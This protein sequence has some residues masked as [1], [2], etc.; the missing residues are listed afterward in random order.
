MTHTATVNGSNGMR[1]S[2]AASVQFPQTPT[3][4]PYPSAPAQPMPYPMPAPAALVKPGVGQRITGP[5]RAHPSLTALILA[6]LA[7]LVIALP[8]AHGIVQSR[9]D[10]QWQPSSSVPSGTLPGGKPHMGAGQWATQTVNAAELNY[11]NSIIAHM[12][13]QQEVGQ[14]IMIEFEESQMT[15]GLAYE[16]SHYNVG[17]VILYAYNVLNPTQMQQFT[18]AMQAN[19][20]LPLLISTDQEGGPVN[21]LYSIDGPLPSAEQIGATN[22]PNFARQRGEQDGQALYNLGINTNLAPVVDVQNI[23]DG[24]GDL[25]GRMFGT[26]PQQ[27]T[28]MAGAYLEGLQ[29]GNHVVGCLKHFPGLGDVPVDPHKQLYTLDRSLDQLRQ[30]DWAPYA[31]LFATGQVGMVMVTHVV[32]P[33]VD[34][35]RPATLSKPV[36]TGVLRDQLHFNGVVVTDGI[37]MKSLSQYSFDQIVLYAVE[38]GVDIISSTY[39][40]A[41][42]AE[43]E[44]VILDAVQNGTISKQQIDDSVRRILLL[45]LR[46]GVL[47]MPKPA[48]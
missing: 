20:T 7:L 26:T 19:A 29:E 46:Y 2:Q 16:I 32:I 8:V 27:V 4:S 6:G 31:S 1:N 36:I 48:A 25:G 5:M 41:S 30:I 40:L 18:Q 28:K 33:A 35:T 12:T 22:D 37:Y 24:E 21:R 15:P 45:K 44:R 9:G 42:T 11:V 38:A 17:S 43:A 10:I 13:L 3:Y 34:P 14:M 47:T 23:P 39:S